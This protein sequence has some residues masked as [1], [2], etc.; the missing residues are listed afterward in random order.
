MS[1]IRVKSQLICSKTRVTPLKKLSIP[2]LELM[3][4]RILVTLRK[5]VFSVLKSQV[6]IEGC[7][8]WLDSKTALYWINNAGEWK[9]FVQHRVDEILKLTHKKGWGHCAGV[10]NPADLGSRGVLASE[11][12]NKRIW[13]QGPHW[14]L[15]EREHWPTEL[16]LDSTSDVNEEKKKSFVT[17]QQHKEAHRYFKTY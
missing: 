1:Q 5:V 15:M 10:C 12:V 6:T 9:Q 3:S 14:L 2:R 8:Y 16:L 13:W 7:R 17:L 4:A 11:L